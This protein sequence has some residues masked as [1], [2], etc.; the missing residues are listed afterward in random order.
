MNKDYELGK[1]MGI[2]ESDIA[3][4]RVVKFFM[5]NKNKPSYHG[6]IHRVVRGS[7]TGISKALHT[8]DGQLE[9]MDKEYVQV[10]QENPTRMISVLMFSLKPEFYESLIKI[11]SSCQTTEG[12]A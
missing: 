6:G 8:L 9:V 10:P 11:Q 12:S 5:N 2:I 3:T 4:K 7:K 1:K